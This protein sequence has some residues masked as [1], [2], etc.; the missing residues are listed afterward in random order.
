MNDYNRYA[1][2]YLTVQNND[3]IPNR[4]TKRNIYEWTFMESCTNKKK[5]THKIH[6]I[7]FDKWIPIELP[8]L[9]YCLLHMLEPDRVK[10]NH[11]N[12]QK[13]GKSSIDRVDN[14]YTTTQWSRCNQ[15]STKSKKRQQNTWTHE[16]NA[17]ILKVT[18][19]S[20]YWRT[21][22]LYEWREKSFMQLGPESWASVSVYLSLSLSIFFFLLWFLRVFFLV[23]RRILLF[24]FGIN[25]QFRERHC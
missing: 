23:L 6:V 10:L 5:S 14:A 12:K 1:N 24:V 8:I 21:T 17:L 16:K 15:M 4:K 25:V 2:V 18:T 13:I 22:S 19:G 20:F 7:H 3:R 11:R 9:I